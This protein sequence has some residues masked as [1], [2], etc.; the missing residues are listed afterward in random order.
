V[1]LENAEAVADAMLAAA[2]NPTCRT[3]ITR[4]NNTG[5]RVSEAR[6]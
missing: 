3:L 2:G 6:A 1:T 5:M 4:A